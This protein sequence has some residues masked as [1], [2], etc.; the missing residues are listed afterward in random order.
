[1]KLRGVYH[2]NVVS[3]FL[4]LLIGLLF[5]PTSNCVNT[6]QYTNVN[7]HLA[8]SNPQQYVYLG[9]ESIKLNINTNGVI[10]YNSVSTINS[11]DYIEAINDIKVNNVTEY[12]NVINSI[13]VDDIKVTYKHNGILTT[14]ILN[15]ND[16]SNIRAIENL[17]GNATITYINPNN[18][19]YAA[20]AHS[21]F[22]NLYNNDNDFGTINT[23]NITQV[24]KSTPNEV[25]HFITIKGNSLGT[26]NKMNEQGIYGTYTNTINEELIPV[27]TAHPGKAYIVT[28][29][30]NTKAYYE[31]N[32][33]DVNLNTEAYNLN[34]TITDQTFLDSTNGIL[35]GMS[36]SP[37]VQDGEL[38]GAISHA[39]TGNYTHCYGL[40]IDKMINNTN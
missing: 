16:L 35:K 33:D 7:N 34:I 36:G 19:Q 8:V 5:I 13:S 14:S 25:G 21:I 37:I 32:I 39:V 27:G 11:G 24:I 28:T 23:N 30:N 22:G 18:L 12:K 20:V 6:V 40:A 26:I 17:S 38:V 31:I 29:I 4:S 2:S 15:K 1:M 9:G 3:V 10:A